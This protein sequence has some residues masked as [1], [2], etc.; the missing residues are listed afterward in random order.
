MSQKGLLTEPPPRETG[1]EP[2]Y[3]VVYVI[4][5]NAADIREAAEYTHRIM[6]DPSS[7]APVLHVLDHRG[8]DAIVDLASEPPG[9]AIQPR[10]DESDQKAHR[11]VQ[12]GG[13]R[14]PSCDS[15]NIDL[16][17]VELDSQHAYQ[18]ASCRTCQRGFSAVYRLVGYGLHVGDS[19]EVHT[20]TA[21]SGEIK[22]RPG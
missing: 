9:A 21:D 7:L 3:R 10:S 14:C 13:T 16:G 1:P 19:F 4:D 8:H 11:F 15:E 6:T 12:A 5:V 2:L 20:I 17:K 18:E 22:G